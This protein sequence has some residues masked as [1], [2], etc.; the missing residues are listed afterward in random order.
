MIIKTLFTITII[1]VLIINTEAIVKIF[2]QWRTMD[3]QFPSDAIRQQAISSQ[4]F[5]PENIIPIDVAVDY[6]SMS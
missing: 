1:F 4:K 5:V 2:K 6:K 3:F